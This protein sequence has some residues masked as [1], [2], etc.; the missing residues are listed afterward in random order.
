MNDEAL[1]D[2]GLNDDAINDD[3][4]A[5]LATQ[6]GEALKAHSRLL[7]TAESCTGGWV[8]QAVTA[9]S[10]SSAWYDRGFV[11]YSNE[12]KHEMLGVSLGTLERCGAVSEE[13]AREMANGTLAHSRAQASLA[14][15]GVAGPGGGTPRNPVGTVCF[16]WAVRGAAAI[17]IACDSER[18]RFD[19]DREAVR[20]QA[21]VHALAGMLAR[22]QP[23]QRT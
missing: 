4:I 6:L 21:V 20:R 5:L 13:T 19:G 1:N 12:A 3:A 15:T 11:T 2:D 22:L 23:L 18:Q 16:A 17:D 8:G 7:A 14:I 9:V 10:G